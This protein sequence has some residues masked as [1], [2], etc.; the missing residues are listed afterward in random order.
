MAAVRPPGYVLEAGRA[1]RHE[2]HATA[3]Q[4]PAAVTLTARYVLETEGPFIMNGT[5]DTDFAL[6]LHCKDL[7]IGYKMGRALKSPLVLHG[8]AQQASLYS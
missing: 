6:K 1:L 7:D 3:C 2:R 8:V 5:F 4:P